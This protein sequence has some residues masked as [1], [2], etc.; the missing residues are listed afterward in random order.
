MP[1]Q[2]SNIRGTTQPMFQ[3]GKD[4]PQF[5]MNGGFL[6]IRNADDT[7]YIPL[8]T[9]SVDEESTD[10]AFNAFE[11]AE[12][13]PY[14]V[15]QYQNGL[16]DTI[17]YYA[18]PGATNLTYT[19]DITYNTSD[20]PTVITLTRQSDSAQFLKTITYDVNDLPDT[21]DYTVV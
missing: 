7:T 18:G 16:P 3:I 9:S 6:E 2:Y 8:R 10:D 1:D 19:A 15:V 17:S 11:D 4:G 14:R 5:R 13:Q 21:V 12:Q 20:L